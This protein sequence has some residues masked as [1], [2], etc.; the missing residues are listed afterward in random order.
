MGEFGLGPRNQET[1]RGENLDHV[2]S[3]EP[4]PSCAAREDRKMLNVT[5]EQ[6]GDLVTL[7]CRGRI[8]R[9]E[10]TGLLCA[11]MRLKEQNVILDLTEVD[12]IDAAGLGALVS[13]QAAGVYLKLVNPCGQVREML[14]ITHL[15]SIFEI[16][17]PEA[18]TTTHE[19]TRAPWLLES[20]F[21]G[22]ASKTF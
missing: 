8:V 6:Q 3:V 5:T 22:G 11:A 14:Q 16:S 12:A 10:E 2:F 1:D 21:A 4:K 13:L 18:S 19:S 15:D 9:G 20:S 7:R 17:G